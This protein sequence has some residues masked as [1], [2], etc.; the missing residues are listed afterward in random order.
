MC[1]YSV[2]SAPF[3]RHTQFGTL[4]VAALVIAIVLIFIISD[5]TLWEAVTTA[6][7]FVLVVCLFLFYCLTI[8]IKDGDNGHPVWN[9]SHQKDFQSF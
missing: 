2:N 6:I 1:S 7:I 9:R 3:Y 5:A 4:T 8:E